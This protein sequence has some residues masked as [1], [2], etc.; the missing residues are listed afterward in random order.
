MGWYWIWYLFYLLLSLFC[1]PIFCDDLV[2]LLWGLASETITQKTKT[3]KHKTVGVSFWERTC[4]YFVS[5]LLDG[6]GISF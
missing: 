3:K 2:H 5:R 6:V 1:P 4:F